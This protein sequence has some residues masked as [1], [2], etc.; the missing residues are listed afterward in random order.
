M[1]T[2]IVWHGGGH[3]YDPYVANERYVYSMECGRVIEKVTFLR[4]FVSSNDII[5]YPQ[6]LA[7]DDAVSALVC[8]LPLVIFSM[9]LY[10]LLLAHGLVIFFLC[11]LN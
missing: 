6:V 2:A 10:W 4:Y 1:I 5:L 7:H 8:H 9:I 3:I 11:A